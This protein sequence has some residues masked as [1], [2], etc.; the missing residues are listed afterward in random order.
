MA[1]PI[2]Y[3]QYQEYLK[4]GEFIGLK[5]AKCGSINFPPMA[6]CRDCS[7]TTLE[8]V[9]LKGEGTI[10]TF[11]VIR[12]APEG[13]KPPYIIAMVELD[14]GPYVIGNLEGITPDETG[15]DLIGKKV[16]M[17][18][19]MVQGDVYSLGDAHVPTFTLME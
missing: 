19:R 12:V 8:P 13:K 4:K 5:C 14:E 10:R 6:V 9:S 15:M 11:T 16:R 17:G 2:T 1:Y 18:T 7:G 3:A